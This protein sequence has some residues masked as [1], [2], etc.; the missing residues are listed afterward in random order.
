MQ[1]EDVE[2]FTLGE[3]FDGE[4]VEFVTPERYEEEIIRME[5]KK[6]DGCEESRQGI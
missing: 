5:R 1:D 6:K 3:I 2:V 4:Q